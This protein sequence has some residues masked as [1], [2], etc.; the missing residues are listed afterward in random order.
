MSDSVTMGVMDEH[1]WI[2]VSHSG[3]N[4]IKMS[5]LVDQNEDYIHFPNIFIFSNTLIWN[6]GK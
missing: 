5:R 1:I 2:A 4:I 3:R 6:N